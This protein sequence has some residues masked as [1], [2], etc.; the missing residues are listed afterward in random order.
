MGHARG[1]SGRRCG[2]NRRETCWLDR[3][4][5]SLLEV[6]FVAAGATLLAAMAIPR[7]T[8]MLEDI[9]VVG[10]VRY[11][12]SRLQQARMDAVM[13]AA[14]VALRF[15]RQ[16]AYRYAVFQDGNGNGVLSRDIDRGVD[17]QIRGAERLSDQFPGVEF[18]VLPGLPAVDASSTPPGADPV[19]VGASDMV[20]FSPMGTATAGSLYI[21][22][23]RGQQYVIRVFGDTGKTR[24]LRFEPRERRWRP[25]S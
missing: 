12:S 7:V 1:R 14:N 24:L 22:G 25:L 5:F 19:R 18:G 8:G 21:R 17:R 15:D 9:R 16:A 20:V 23:S 13:R 6:V 11:V 2:R 3:G 10:A 4:G